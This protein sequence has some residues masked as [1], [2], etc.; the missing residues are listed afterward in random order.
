VFIDDVELSVSPKLNL[1]I[2]MSCFDAL[3]LPNHF[4]TT[5]TILSSLGIVL[6]GAIPTKYDPWTKKAQSPAVSVRRT[7][8]GRLTH[9][10]VR[11]M[12]KVTCGELSYFSYFSN[13]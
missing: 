5:A 6:E 7:S 11:E 13:F 2:K 3:I 12:H 4:K 1:L 10:N 9:I 8:N